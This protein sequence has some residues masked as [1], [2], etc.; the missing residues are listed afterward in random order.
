MMGEKDKRIDVYIDEA[1]PFARP[2]LKRIRAAFHKGCPGLEET[3]KWGAPGFEYKGLLGGMASSK[4]HV[5][6][7]FWK[8]KLM[9][10]P[11]GILESACGAG[12]FTF[13]AA[14]V[15]DLPAERILI[16]CVKEARRLNDEG[17]KAPAKKRR[18]KKT[19]V[20]PDDFQK[21]LDGNRKARETFDGFPYSKRRDYVDWLTGARRPATREKRL[22]TAIEWLAEGKS[23]NWKYD[24]C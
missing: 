3:I 17:L 10:D 11:A 9:Q 7:G 8:A 22:A 16:A 2:I 21:A 15:G 23:R 1:E 24:S 13:K 6:Y 12:N 14:S 18:P 5:S 4:K 19:I 20:I